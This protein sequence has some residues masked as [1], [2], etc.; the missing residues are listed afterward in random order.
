[1]WK[2]RQVVVVSHGHGRTCLVVPFSTDPPKH[3]RGYHHL[4][5]VGTYPF[6]ELGKDSWVKADM[7]EAVSY[8]RLDRV[9]INGRFSPARLSDADFLAVQKCVLDAL[10]L[11][12]LTPQL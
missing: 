12:R 5:P 4:I 8:D 10:S 2:R 6:F 7:M 1:M 11:S 9:L 3:V